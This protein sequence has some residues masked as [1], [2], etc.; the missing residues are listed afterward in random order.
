MDHIEMLRVGYGSCIGLIGKDGGLFMVDW[1]SMNNKQG[2][3]TMSE[4]FSFIE[5][6]YA[7]CRPREFLLTHYHRDH[8]WGFRNAQ[9]KGYFNKVYLP[10]LP[11]DKDGGSPLLLFAAA[12]MGVM[13]HST[14][15]AQVSTV[16][17]DIFHSL[18][19][20][21]HPEFIRVIKSGDDFLFDGV[22]YQVLSPVKND[23]PYDDAFLKAAEEL[24]ALFST[25]YWLAYET[26][27]KA[28]VDCQDAFSQ[29][30]LQRETWRVR[31]AEQ[32]R[33]AYL[34]L[35]DA[36]ESL[37]ENAEKIMELL[38]DREIRELHSRAVNMASVVFHTAV[39][40]RDHQDILMTGDAPEEVTALFEERLHD[41]YAVVK[42]PHHGTQS[43]YWKL[44]SE[45][46]IDHMLIENGEYQAGGT[47]SDRYFSAGWMNHC[48]NPDA[49]AYYQQTGDCCNKLKVCGE[50]S[51]LALH[52]GK[53]YRREKPCGIYVISPEGGSG[54]L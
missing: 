12:A 39:P 43:G 38:T 41:G 11:L 47:I 54:C 10:Y 46:G 29:S 7:Q 18:G 37:A 28:Y 44:F 15:S 16:C 53:V 42:A 45:I 19:C 9:E 26:F 31:A 8:L 36:A 4:Q 21:S 3:R 14:D 32:V 13:H 25:E 49:C 52:C 48:T 20:D 23:F 35:E 30:N 17:L 27:Q 5:N 40:H 1:G 22:R 6:R 2:N 50:F 34:E 24:R 51:G 33:K